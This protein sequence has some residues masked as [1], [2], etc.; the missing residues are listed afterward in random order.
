MMNN[1]FRYFVLFLFLLFVVS[2]LSAASGYSQASGGGSSTGNGK[3]KM[4]PAETAGNRAADFGGN[5]NFAQ[6]AEMA[7]AASAELRNAYSGYVINQ[8]AWSMGIRN[9]FPRLSFSISEND[10]LQ[11][12]GPDSFSKGYS[13]NLDQLLWDGG[14]TSISRSIQRLELNAAYNRLDRMAAEVAESALS[15]YRNVLSSRTVLAIREASLET[16][17]EQRRIL[18]SEVELGAALPVDLAEA[19]LTLAGAEIEIISLRSDL[20]EMEQQ[21]VE[22]LGMENMPELTEKVDIRRNAVLPDYETALGLAMERNPELSDAR[23]S[24]IKRQN[25]L[26]YASRSWIPGIR[27]QGSFGLNGRTYPLTRYTWAVSLN[28]ELAGPYL[29][30]N[31][32]IQAGHE[33]PNDYNA[34]LQNAVVPAPNIEA[35]LSRRQAEQTLALEHEIYRAAIDRMARFAR[36]GIE[37]CAMADK[38]RA[39]TVEAIALAAERLRLE[40]I[41]LNLGHITRLDLMESMIEFTK[42]EIAAVNAAVSLMEAE[43][44][45]ERLLDLKPGDLKTFAGAAGTG[46]ASGSVKSLQTPIK[47]YL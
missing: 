20:A 34:Q 13:V 32:S 7:V 12:L 3:E 27:L 26:K 36:R 47:E 22:I 1:F 21:F 5:I 19:D 15:A 30:N 39:L 14:R 40:E 17:A 2:G 31:F 38:M 37:K 4:S 42:K 28:I 43:R 23:L 10:R 8:Q 24:I 44:E 18:A 33:P 46:F 29:Q 6:A 11:A 16:L 25:E 9:Y 35:G 45:L 41:R